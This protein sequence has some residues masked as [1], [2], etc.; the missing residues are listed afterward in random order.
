MMFGEADK[1]FFLKQI[2]G[3]GYVDT[4]N[5]LINMEKAAKPADF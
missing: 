5:S 1:N 4:G 2:K 3:C